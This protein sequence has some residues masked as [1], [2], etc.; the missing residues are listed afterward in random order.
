[1]RRSERS[2]V[3]HHAVIRAVV[4]FALAL[5]GMLLGLPTAHALTVN[6][7]Y[8]FGTPEMDIGVGVVA[9]G[10]DV[11]VC[12]TTRGALP[13][14]TNLGRGDA[15]VEKFDGAGTPL[16]TIQFGSREQDLVGGCAANATGLYVVGQT[17]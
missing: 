6:A 12:G 16:W 14:Q 1:T 7:V 3:S 17:K 4:G 11:F 5:T 10:G 2:E 13:G 8:Q 15:F 9:H